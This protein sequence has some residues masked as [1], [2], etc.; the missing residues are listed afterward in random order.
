MENRRRPATSKTLIRGTPVRDAVP[1]E[2][3]TTILVRYGE[4]G[5][6]SP[7][8]RARWEKRLVENVEGAM[9]RRG[10]EGD[11]R[12]E[13]GRVFVRTNRPDAA[14]DALAHTFGVVSASVAEQVPAEVDAIAEH[15]VR[16][17]RTMLSQGQSFAVRARRVGEH[18]FT[19]MDVQKQVGAAV[20]TANRDRDVRVDLTDPEVEL[21]VEIREKKAYFFRATTRGPGGIPLG[22][23]GRV[24]ALL[25]SP[26]AALAGWLFMKRGT[27]PLWLA[28]DDAL[29]EDACRALAKWAPLVRVTRVRVPPEW[30]GPE[31]RRAFLI[32]AAGALARPRKGQAVVL[33]DGLAG[34]VALSA[35]DRGANLPVFRPL[36]GYEGK[37][38]EALAAYA[39]VPGVRDEAEPAGV[40]SPLAVP[41]EVVRDALRAATTWEVRA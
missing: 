15:V 6:K 11:V 28:P 9:M 13:W 36:S 27:T 31:R 8:V 38:L 29:P 32:R 16:A 34:A 21:A 10:A 14:L 24:V 7:G 20:W 12:R 19:S 41:P 4:L 40:A 18:A 23:Q 2:P 5:I 33:P 30:D 3:W 26:R 37:E 1:D 17:S 35:L 39:E 22:T 25:D